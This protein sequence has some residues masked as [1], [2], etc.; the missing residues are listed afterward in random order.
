MK[1]TPRIL[2]EGL[3]TC[4]TITILNNHHKGTPP[5]AGCI[6][7]KTDPINLNPDHFT[8]SMINAV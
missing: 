3:T 7:K 5:C 4:L 1:I 2:L 8:P 6:L